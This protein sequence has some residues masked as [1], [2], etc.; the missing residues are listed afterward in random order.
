MKEKIRKLTKSKHGLWILIPLSFISWTALF[1][2]LPIVAYKLN[3]K[4]IK[5]RNVKAAFF[6]GTVVALATL[7]AIFDMNIWIHDLNVY[8][9]F[10]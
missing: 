1:V 5:M 3:L 7:H 6:I 9:G 2:T 8:L 10:K 4:P